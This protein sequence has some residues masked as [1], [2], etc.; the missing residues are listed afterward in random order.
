M[1]IG[2]KDKNH[3][4]PIFVYEYGLSRPMCARKL[5][6]NSCLLQQLH[7]L[8][9]FQFLFENSSCNVVIPSN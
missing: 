6:L 5:K 3:S 8:K 7:P 2:F 4:N 1:E 9:V